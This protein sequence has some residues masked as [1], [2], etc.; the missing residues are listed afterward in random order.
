MR[1][2]KG[3]TWGPLETGL[4]KASYWLVSSLYEND[5]NNTF[6]QGVTC[7]RPFASF[8]LVLF[9]L[10]SSLRISWATT[11]LG[12]LSSFHEHQHV[13]SHDADTATPW[14]YRLSDRLSVVGSCRRRV[15]ME[16]LERRGQRYAGRVVDAKTRNWK[17]GLW[18]STIVSADAPVESLDEFV[19]CVSVRLC[20][21]SSAGQA[22]R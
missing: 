17:R 8:S 21:L 10:E 4:G 3:R 7:L 20:I 5:D 13:D 9:S 2:G 11:T 19:L 1:E 18:K 22:V 14:V 15:S 12:K 6:L 16:A